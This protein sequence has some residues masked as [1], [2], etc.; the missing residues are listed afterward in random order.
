MDL[1]SSPSN[2]ILY[3]NF[4]QDSTCFAVGTERGF[5]VYSVDPFC[6]TARHDLEEGGKGVGVIATLFRTHILAFSGGGARPWI[7]PH[8]VVLWDEHQAKSIAELTF[9]GP[10]K[11][12]RLTSKLLVVALDTKVYVYDMQTLSLLDSIDTVSNPKGLCCISVGPDRMVLVT[13]GTQRKG[14]AAVV[15]YP[16]SFGGS[17]SSSS[18][19]ASPGGSFS[20]SAEKTTIINAHQ[21]EV[22]CMAADAHGLMLATASETGTVIRIWDTSGGGKGAKLQELRRGKDQAEIYSM[23]FNSN[24]EFLVVASEKG[25]V[26]VFHLMP[27][28]EGREA[29]PHL[30]VRSLNAP[31]PPPPLAN[32][33]TSF[34]YFKSVSTYFASEWSL[35]QFRVHDYCPPSYRF[36]AAFGP[37]PNTIVVV[38]ANGWIC[39]ARFDPAQGGE[40]TREVAAQFD[41]N[42]VE[43]S[44][45]GAGRP[46]LRSA[47]YVAGGASPS[48][49]A[50]LAGENGG[51]PEVPAASAQ[52]DAKQ[53]PSAVGPEVES[54]QDSVEMAREVAGQSGEQSVE[55]DKEPQPSSVSLSQAAGQNGEPNE[56]G[57][58]SQADSFE[59]RCSKRPDSVK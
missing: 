42:S 6:L 43:S 29:A 46:S 4:N 55:S 53:A 1:Q 34:S 17:P 45:A 58:A 11:S 15:S 51:Q 52:A 3:C 33:G 19:S 48:R 14:R 23:A 25:T 16:R 36:I 35:A 44:G 32:S 57:M 21:S 8:K 30:K 22:A 5:R 13:L 2:E 26:H 38:A 37:E 27:G 20:P 7:P 50:P 10:V 41:D 56:F 31:L 40:M 9:N 28:P 47:S 49:S 39:K 12:I 54:A 18:P 24:S 59:E